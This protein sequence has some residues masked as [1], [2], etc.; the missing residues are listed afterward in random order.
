M[1]LRAPPAKQ[2][3]RVKL[4]LEGRSWPN[5]QRK[6]KRTV[7][8]C[9]ALQVCQPKVPRH[10]SE[11]APTALTCLTSVCLSA[12]VAQNTCPCCRHRIASP[13]IPDGP[14]FGPA[15][16]PH[17]HPYICPLPT[18]HCPLPP[19]WLLSPTSCA[20]T[21]PAACAP[22]REPQAPERRP[23]SFVSQVN[24]LRQPLAAVSRPLRGKPSPHTGT[25]EP[26]RTPPDDKTNTRVRPRLASC[27][28]F[29]RRLA[30][31]TS[32]LSLLRQSSNAGGPQP[33][34]EAPLYPTSPRP[35][36]SPCPSGAPQRN[37]NVSRGD[38][39]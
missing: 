29:P 14:L 12:V 11:T 35:A 21:T 3:S 6:K 28:L 32:R 4:L 37:R 5:K 18:A 8:L 39:C 25:V 33:L 1:Q 9:T 7:L 36:P 34:A 27:P 10:C 30:A 20:A 17:P 2:W 16:H 22:R 24:G 19:S 23:P 31:P 13:S 26:Y 15:P 38:D